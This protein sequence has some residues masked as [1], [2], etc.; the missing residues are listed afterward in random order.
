[1]NESICA[2]STS[3]PLTIPTNRPATTTSAHASGHATWCWATS[4]MASTLDRP[5]PYPIERSK[6]PVTI[7]TVAP[8]A[9]TAGIDWFARIERRLNNVGKESGLSAEKTTIT[10]TVSASRPQVPI[11]WPP[12]L[13]LPAAARRAAEFVRGAGA[14]GVGDGA[15]V[16]VMR[17]LRSRRRPAR[18]R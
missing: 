8:R 17:P 7:G 2:S 18:S 11:T 12:D 10:R 4:H 14:P 9:S 16:V 1:M 5:M 6:R 3:S 13:G 15:W